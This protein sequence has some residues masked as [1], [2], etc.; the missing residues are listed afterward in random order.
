MTDTRYLI[1]FDDG[2]AGM[3]TRLAPLEPGEIIHDCGERYRVV[4]VEPPPS[5][6]GFGRAWAERETPQTSHSV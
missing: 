3:R 5:E 1:T 4:T 6:A 2:G